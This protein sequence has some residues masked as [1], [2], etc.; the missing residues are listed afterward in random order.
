VEHVAMRHRLPLLPDNRAAFIS[1]ELREY[2]EERGMAHTRGNPYH[3]MTQGKIERYR[4]PLKNVVTL[5]NFYLRWKLE[6]EIS[7]FARIHN[8]ECMHGALNNLTPAGVYRGR[9]REILTARERL[10]EQA[11]RRRRRIN[12]GLSVTPEERMPPA[13]YPSQVSLVPDAHLPPLG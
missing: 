9:G 4:R 1:K 7:R 5:Q 3:P 6:Q 12:R 11:L 13:L 8:H 10:R 2:L